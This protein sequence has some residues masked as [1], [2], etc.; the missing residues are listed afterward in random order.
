[1]N[2]CHRIPNI[3][4]SMQ[5]KNRPPRT[6]QPSFQLHD[7]TPPHVMTQCWIKQRDIIYFGL[8]SFGTWCCAIQ[9]LVL[10]QKTV[11]P[12]S[13]RIEAFQEDCLTL[14]HEDSRILH[15]NHKHH[16]ASHLTRFKASATPLPV[17]QICQHLLNFPSVK[18][19]RCAARSGIWSVIIKYTK[20]IR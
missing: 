14:E 16:T 5:Y 17:T 9:W 15:R 12:L 10:F 3:L 6:T 7:C 1:M 11:V 20:H 8:K 18:T 4:F 19:V 2:D 13:S